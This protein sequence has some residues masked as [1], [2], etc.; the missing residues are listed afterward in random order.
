MP[1]IGLLLAIAAAL[2]AVAAGVLF[3][4]NFFEA[5][6][7]RTTP[8]ETAT[9]V[10]NNSEHTPSP[11]ESFTTQLKEV[12]AGNGFAVTFLDADLAKWQLAEG[13]KIER[14]SLGHNGPVFARLTSNTP[15]DEKSFHWPRLGLSALLPLQFGQDSN[16]QRIQVGVVARA[17]NNDT[18][19]AVSVAYATQQAGN[20]GWR[21]FNVKSEFQLFKFV[22]D[23][24]V[25]E[26]GYTASPILTL[27]SDPSGS[28]Q[29]VE[30]L[31]VYV[32]I[33][34]KE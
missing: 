27:N 25:V 16:G 9:A 12:A 29:S 22:W 11:E 34:K 30:I 6:P 21:K 32:K 24:P 3:F 31:G 33:V 5:T 2:I 28:G 8:D 7:T 1:R 15:L 14:F 26:T 20:T 23:V 4:T 17:A 19:S 13:F 10:S 18:T